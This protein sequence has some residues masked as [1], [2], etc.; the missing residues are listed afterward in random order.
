MI[1]DDRAGTKRTLEIRKMYIDVG[2]F[3]SLPTGIAPEKQLHS[4]FSELS[5]TSCTG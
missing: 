4:I 1:K 5:Q 3:C 2:L